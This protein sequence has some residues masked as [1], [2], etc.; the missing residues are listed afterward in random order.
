M[1]SALDSFTPVERKETLGAMVRDQL[2]SAIMAG[3]FKPGEKLTIRA[4]ANALNVSLTPARE[5]LYN[6]VA[7]GALESRPNGTVCVPEIDEKR[8]REV[9]RIRIALEGLAAREAVTG[10][11]AEIVRDLER[12]NEDLIKADA[13]KDYAALR[14]LN[15]KF[16]FTIYQAAN[17]PQLS[18]MIENCWLM[19]GSYL[20]VLY[21]EYGKV[22]VGIDIH[23]DIIKAIKSRDADKL[24]AAIAKDIRSS[25][26]WLASMIH[27][28]A[29]AGATK[30]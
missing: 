1:S 18:K 10:L 14:T 16:H 4:V 3:Q 26:E 13:V 17:M 23:R 2:R 28:R 9:S 24:E 22:K 11:T 5:A 21:P 19:I 30:E 29:E 7:E 6:L 8:L 20:N 25:S 27:S 12:I 15:W